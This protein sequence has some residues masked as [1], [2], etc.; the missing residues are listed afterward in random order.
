[1]PREFRF[2]DSLHS[3]QRSCERLVSDAEIRETVQTGSVIQTGQRGVHGGT[4]RLYKKFIGHRV[5]V[6][7]AEIHQADCYVITTYE[8]ES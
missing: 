2:H 5:V 3:L 6:V 4:K 7:V 8:E 1:M